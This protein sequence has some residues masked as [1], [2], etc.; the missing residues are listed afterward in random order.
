MGID[1][2]SRVTGYGVIS[3]QG[4]RMECVAYGA[5]TARANGSFPDRLKKI[6]SELQLLLERY[7]PAALAVESVF[8]ATNARSAL[9]LGH[10]RGVILLAAAQAGT[11]LY[12]YSPLEVKKAV[13]GYGRADKNQIQ[14]MVRR[15][16]SL[17]QPPHPYDAADALAI[18]LCHAFRSSTGRLLLPRPIHHNRH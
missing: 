1:P 10:T 9:I 12:E 17:G 15:L 16:L 7:S 13:V 5:I 4:N 3:A 11:E 6:H 18:A 8:Y 14:L 2:G